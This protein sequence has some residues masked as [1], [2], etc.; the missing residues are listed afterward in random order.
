MRLCR[1]NQVVDHR[2]VKLRFDE[3]Q[4]LGEDDSLHRESSVWS[5]GNRADRRL[6]YLPS[7][8]KGLGTIQW[9]I[10]CGRATVVTIAP[11]K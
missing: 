7:D 11:R 4:E 3:R 8:Y 2:H 10:R 6:N 5:K 9:L 1:R